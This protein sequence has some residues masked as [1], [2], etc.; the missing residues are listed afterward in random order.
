MTPTAG[1]AAVD[2]DLGRAEVDR[3]CE[4]PAHAGAVLRT[5][6]RGSGARAAPGRPVAGVGRRTASHH[7][8][9]GHPRNKSIAL[10]NAQSSDP[11]S[12]PATRKTTAVTGIRAFT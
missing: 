10:S 11:Q 12:G 5:A 4:H 8:G 9:A 6:G 7:R 3:W 2:I 1:A